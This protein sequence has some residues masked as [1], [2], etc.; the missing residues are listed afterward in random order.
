MRT[1]RFY[2]AWLWVLGPAW[3]LTA[4]PSRAQLQTQISP[5]GANVVVT[6]SSAVFVSFTLRPGAIGAP[7]NVSSALGQ[8]VVLSPSDR[9][10]R[11][12]IGTNLV[13]L[14][15]TIAPGQTG[16]A[17]E[18]LLIPQ[19]VSI[20]GLK[21][22]LDRFFY[23]RTFS[24]DVD[25]SSSVARLTCRLG[26]SA[27][28]LFSI[29]QVTLYFDN[30]RGEATVQQGST[31]L[32]AFAEVH[33]NGTGLVEGTWEVSEPSPEGERTFR[34]IETIKT[35]VTYGDRIL[36]R[37]PAVPGLPAQVR[38]Q[39]VVALR[40]SSPPS[41]FPLPVVSYYVTE[42]VQP[43]AQRTIQLLGPFD[44]TSVQQP[45]ITFSWQPVSQAVEYRFELLEGD[46]HGLPSKLNVA[47][48]PLR[49]LEPA[50]AYPILLPQ[51]STE[52]RL[53]AFSA[54]TDLATTRFLLNAKHLQRLRRGQAYLWRVVALDAEGETVAQ[55]PVRRITLF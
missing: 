31:D 34:V 3:L 6:Q 46:P 10:V 41:G 39:H 32:H 4:S 42:P 21:S 13:P 25:G 23:E 12:V 27:F 47:T 30:E 19:D 7:T 14:Q 38:G 33:Y 17:V 15:T 24:S 5:T 49:A 22:G 40:I 44:N 43:Q 50:S 48:D 28:G 53:V 45:P 29:G 36:L 55:S 54:Q 8:F 1:S 52:K 16:T 51:F 26:S 35:Y 11:E 20:R 37:T 9:S 2:R 18:T